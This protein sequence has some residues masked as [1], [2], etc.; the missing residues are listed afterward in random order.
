MKTCYAPSGLE[1]TY[2][3]ENDMD[4]ASAK[5]QNL[6]LNVFL[7]MCHI[8]LIP[9]DELM[10]FRSDREGRKEGN[11]GEIGQDARAMALTTEFT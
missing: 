9:Q 11:P 8:S 7:S 5:V 1:Q 6:L 4:K 3:L 2:E 10:R